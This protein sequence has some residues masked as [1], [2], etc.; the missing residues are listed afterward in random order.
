M[1]VTT[2][3]A[4]ARHVLKLAE[5]GVPWPCLGVAVERVDA[6]RWPVWVAQLEG[7]DA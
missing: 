7:R 6:A 4:K 1:W 3:A 5:I 2:D